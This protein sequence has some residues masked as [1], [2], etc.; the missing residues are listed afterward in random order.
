MEER[1]QSTHLELAEDLVE[2]LF[3]LNNVPSGVNLDRFVRLANTFDAV[4]PITVNAHSDQTWLRFT[5]KPLSYLD[6]CAALPG[7]CFVD[8]P[9][10]YRTW[11]F[12]FERCISTAQ[13]S[14]RPPELSITTEFPDLP[15]QFHGQEGHLR[16]A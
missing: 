1:Y 9:P 5:G 3:I 16:Y 14:R 12:V 6:G 15:D 13:G 10:F 4:D 2:F 8:P 7:L 11:C